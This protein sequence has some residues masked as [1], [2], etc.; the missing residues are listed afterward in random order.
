M[1]TRGFR[2]SC[3]GGKLSHG[4]TSGFAAGLRH[5]PFHREDLR[6]I[7]TLVGG[8]SFFIRVAVVALIYCLVTNGAE[9]NFVNRSFHNTPLWDWTVLQ[10]YYFL[11]SGK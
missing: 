10:P 9:D 3:G 4:V 1:Q 8:A 5:R 7:T 2:E 11:K 6:H